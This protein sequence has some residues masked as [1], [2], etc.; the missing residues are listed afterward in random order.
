MRGIKLFRTIVPLL[1]LA[2]PLSA[3]QTGAVTG[4]VTADGSAAE[5]AQVILSQTV[6]GAQYGGL[7]NSTGRFNI[8]GVPA[9]S[10]DVSIQMIG[11][12][13]ESQ[14]ITVDGGGTAVV[15]FALTSTALT[16]GGIEVL[17]ERAEE[18]RT[19]VAFTDVS[20]AQIQTQLGS[21]D[22]PLVLSV[23]PSVY[24]TAQGGGAG[25][26]RI[27][28]RGFSQRNTAV[29]INGVPVNDMEN[30]WVYWSNWDGLGDAA[31][32]IQ[33]QR[34][35]SAV[36]LATPSIGGTLNVITD[37]SQQTPGYNLKQ[38]FGSGRFLKTTMTASTGPIGRF[39][40][41]A[42]GVRKQGDGLID[43][44]WTDAWSYYIASQF[45]FSDRN[46]LELYTVGAPQRHGQNLYKLNVA[47]LNRHFA[48]SLDDYDPSALGQFANEAGRYWSPNLGGVDPSYTGRQFTSTGPGNGVFSRHDRSFLNERENYFHKPQV[49]LNWYSYLGNGLTANTVAYYSGGEG[50]G[51]GTYG[52]L[53]WDYT[54]GQRYPDWNATIDRNRGN[55]D[56]GSSGI[57]RNSVNNQDTYG[58]IAK[59]Q[60][61]FSNDFVTELGV[62]WR[63][64]TIEHYR[65]VRD[66]LGGDFYNDCF[67]GCSSDFWTEAQGNRGLGDKINYHNENDVN[68]IGAHLQAEK[69]SLAGSYYGM[70]GVSRISYDFTDFFTRSGGGQLKLNSGG[71]TGYQMKGGAVRNV[72]PEWSVYGNAGL[73]SKVPI[74]DG[75]IDD[76]LGILNPD[77]KNETFLSF[78]AGTRFR[79]LNRQFSFDGNVYFT[80]W[81]DRTRNQFIRNLMGDNAD[82]LVNLLGVDARHMGVELEAAFQPADF[83]RFDGA[84]SFGDWKYT[85]NPTGTFKPDDRQG[86]T[87]EYNFYLNGLYV[88]DAPQ[89]QVAY[90]LS[91]F[92][93]GGLYLQ[94]VGKTFGKHYA[95]YD[96]FG[97]TSNVDEGVQSWSPPG[98]TV[99][100]VHASY[101]L[102]TEMASAL[103]GNV[104][105]F[106]HA[107]NIFDS[108]YI[109][110]A[111]DNS[112][113]N[114]YWD[115]AERDRGQLSHK[116]DDAEVFLGFPRSLNFGFQIFH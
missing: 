41:T 100:D 105:L 17:A 68:W 1:F 3:Q 22:L 54:Y 84:L 108:V 103:G 34:G 111:V 59:L 25:D 19:P 94:A 45:T 5:S 104:R 44:T 13:A 66:L 26:A 115:A 24:S 11:F 98:Y 72:N 39:A 40:M 58:F 7:T 57:L 91:V 88:G 109:Q 96:P 76:N 75:V 78:E 30:G 97:R 31:T 73:V 12:T 79:S 71:L 32:S 47:T 49:N 16:L 93:S 102:A 114:G 99:F 110:D 86:E 87:Q 116:A 10:Y 55:E 46:R 18:R 70:V 36:N 38:E 27:N 29:M 81:N 64:A 28:V 50:G 48:A 60:K 89:F 83:L 67:R 23:T 74:F 113:F 80:Q 85:N 14:R 52:S 4:S 20:K 8:V 90:A 35:L 9:G 33:L 82:G 69:S 95:D 53:R 56:G 37:P 92:P 2:A 77:P 21:R 112:R 65:E 51:T 63:T 106:I 43:G 101:R 42:S 62:D 107:F 15:D 6:T 61:D